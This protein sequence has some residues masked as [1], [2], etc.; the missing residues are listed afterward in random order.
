[1]TDKQIMLIEDNPDDR[2]LTIRALRKNNVLNPVTVASNGAE[3]LTM[4]FGDDDR[5]QGN[6]GAHPARP[7]TA[8][9]RRARSPPPHPRRRADPASSRSRPHV[10]QAG[11]DLRA[12]Y[13]LGANGY[14]RKPVTFSEFSEGYTLSACSGSCSTNR[15]RI[16]R[17][18]QPLA[19][20]ARR[21]ERHPR[22]TPIAGRQLPMSRGRGTRSR[23]VDRRTTTART[24]MVTAGSCIRLSS[25]TERGVSGRSPRS[26]AP[27]VGRWAARA[28]W[29]PVY[30][31]PAAEHAAG[32]IARC[33]PLCSPA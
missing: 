31:W 22:R 30:P 19:D 14:V 1:M 24:T 27:S 5:D 16:P 4:L 18:E 6:P 3:A 11:E 8:Q 2:D 7:E 17:P 33:W 23:I 28:A 26:A 13:D 10:L 29:R 25:G 9:G 21:G 20:R 32:R 12:A 15:R